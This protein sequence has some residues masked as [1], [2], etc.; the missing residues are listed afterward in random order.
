M[1]KGTSEVEGAG[2]A[3]DV[4]EGDQNNIGLHRGR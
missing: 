2:I 4:S 3:A 1:C